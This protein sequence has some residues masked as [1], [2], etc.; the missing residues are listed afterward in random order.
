MAPTATGHHTTEALAWCQQTSRSTSPK[1]P[2]SSVA[3]S[4][5]STRY[6][7]QRAR[8][9]INIISDASRSDPDHHHCGERHASQLH[10]TQY[11]RP[12]SP[13][14]SHKSLINGSFHHCPETQSPQRPHPCLH[15]SHP[16]QGLHISPDSPNLLAFGSSCRTLL[17]S[18]TLKSSTHSVYS[19]LLSLTSSDL[20]SSILPNST[21]FDPIGSYAPSST[22]PSS[23]SSFSSVSTTLSESNNTITGVATTAGLDLLGILAE[24]LDWDPQQRGAPGSTQFE[25]LG[26]ALPS[27]KEVKQKL[28]AGHILG[29]LGL[30]EADGSRRNSFSTLTAPLI[31]MKARQ[32]DEYAKASRATPERNMRRRREVVASDPLNTMTL[33]KRTALFYE[34]LYERL[35]PGIVPRAY[36][37]TKL[38]SKIHDQD[39]NFAALTLSISLL[40]LLGLTLPP[41]CS[42]SRNA[43]VDSASESDRILVMPTISQDNR[44]GS[45]DKF[46]ESTGL[47]EHILLIRLSTNGGGI[48]FGQAPTLETV[49]TSFFL[50]I[51]LYN[52]DGGDAERFSAWRDASFFRFCEAITLAKILGLDQ[53]KMED[54]EDGKEVSEAV[55]VRCLLVRAERWWAK[56]KASYVCQMEAS[57]PSS[58]G[59]FRK[60]VKSDEESSSDLSPAK[61]H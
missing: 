16:H 48:A 50:S 39:P 10:K 8:S 17:D 29:S 11:R 49:L 44:S 47:I 35:C 2:T 53:V 3:S 32:S 54:V 18:Q 41:T 21:H 6:Q 56:E 42:S 26:Q 59:A 5:G 38:G 57:S 60:R 7:R 58:F 14:T 61:R 30:L 34:N 52:L 1:L 28:W 33:T 25:L 12:R 36:I 31:P 22:S 37:Y 9:S 4:S 24:E 51:A 15:Q 20:P 40:G 45:Q 23:K 27:H 46:S 13:R 43:S 55:K 19:E